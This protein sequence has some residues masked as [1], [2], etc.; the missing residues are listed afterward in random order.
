MHCPKNKGFT[1]IEVM[2]VVTIIGILAAIAIPFYGEH[3][4]KGKRAEATSALTTTALRLER[5]FTQFNTYTHADCQIN[6]EDAFTT[7]GSHYS[8]SIEA[9]GT[10]YTITAEPNFTD[11]RCGTLALTHRGNRSVTG[12][13]DVSYCW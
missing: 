9:N 2:I 10:S 13:R 4:N 3:I 7:E 8:V 6:I 5:C 1:L 11:N 12:S